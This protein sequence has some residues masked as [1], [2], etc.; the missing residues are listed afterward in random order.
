MKRVFRAGLLATAAILLSSG[1]GD[2]D[3]M[4]LTPAVSFV[5]VEP[6]IL[7]TNTAESGGK[8]RQVARFT[9]HND[10]AT[11]LGPGQHRVELEIGSDRYTLTPQVTLEPLADTTFD[12][13]VD[14][15]PPGAAATLSVAMFFENALQFRTSQPWQHQRQWKLY[16]APFSHVD[17]GYT[18]SQQAVLTKQLH[19]INAA[20]E[21][22][23]QTS[24]DPAYD[25]DSRFS[26][27]IEG[28]WAAFEYLRTSD[29]QAVERFLG[30]VRAGRIEVA[31]LLNNHTNKFMG[32]EALWRSLYFSAER[33]QREHGVPVASALLHD[34]GDASSVV[35]PLYRCGIRYIQY[36]ANTMHYAIPPL[37]YFQEPSDPESRL[38]MWFPPNVGEYGENSTL[39]LRP[40]IP[41]SPLEPHDPNAP[42][43]ADYEQ[44]VLDH[45][46]WLQSRGLPPPGVLERFD[47]KGFHADY[48]YDA[49]LVTY[50]PAHDGDNGVQDIT[51][52]D[53][54]RDWNKKYVYPRL[55]VA[56]VRD[57]FEYV[58][59]NFPERI[60]SLTGDFPGFWGE[61]IFF[62]VLQADPEKEARNR[63]FTNQ[64]ATAEK[65]GVVA[66]QLAPSFSMST[67]DVDDAFEKIIL[68]NDHNPGPVPLSGYPFTQDDVQAWK[69]TRKQWSDETAAFAEGIENS[70]VSAVA[71]RVSVDGPSIVVFN[72]SSWERQE[73]VEAEIDPA[74]PRFAIVTDTGEPV[75]Y[76]VI[77]GAGTPTRIAFEAS[78]LPAVGYRTF[79]IVT[80]D[81]VPGFPTSL[82]VQQE[83]GVV[84][85]ENRFYRATI[86]SQA[87]GG[88]ISLWDKELGRE[89]VRGDARYRLDQFVQFTRAQTVGELGGTG[90]NLADAPGFT[91]VVANVA[92]NGPVRAIVRLTG[93][94]NSAIRIPD[95]IKL[96]I[97]F[98]GPFAVQKPAKLPPI[99]QSNQVNL[100]QDIVFYDQI[101]RVDFVQQFSDTPIQLTENAFAY[102]VDVPGFTLKAEFPYNPVRIGP[103]DPFALYG[104]PPSQQGDLLMTATYQGASNLFSLPTKWMDGQPPDNMFRHWLDVSNSDFGVTFSARESGAIVPGDFTELTPGQFGQQPFAPLPAPGWYH[105]G[106]GPTWLG[107]LLYGLEAG[108]SY[109][110]HASLTSHRGR[111]DAIENFAGTRT[112][113]QFGWGF[114]TPLDVR[115]Q[116]VPQE[117]S[118]PPMASFVQIDQPN[119]VLVTMKRAEDG[120]AIV[121]RLYETNGLATR[122]QITL[123]FL[124]CISATLA[125]GVERSVS[126]LPSRGSAFTLDLSPGMV[127]T[128]RVQSCAEASR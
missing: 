36:S 51:P 6:T 5:S 45:L 37:F 55:K 89:L 90:G 62:S 25:T 102:P 107:Q 108:G 23:E 110:F 67:Q 10:T 43:P 120:R 76:Q 124:A 63:A 27:T 105:L 75:P 13:F 121:L 64:I 109:T 98:L 31:G 68:N 83:G 41:S 38:L 9:V 2:D 28:S 116:P 29:P 78:H 80:I 8:T 4:T 113:A 59:Q 112:A 66:A 35:Q 40:P 50:Y 53:V 125:D 77:S 96:V 47:M 85:L 7:F 128:V 86:D 123:P 93:T 60:P 17:V 100:V 73:V 111:A 11:P 101:K 57:F 104:I 106:V 48:P 92:E 71:E 117:G 49:Y 33:M 44:R 95:G 94:Y 79:H 81:D 12:V 65:F 56:R 91:A 24:A 84:I 119:V 20:M 18:N 21:L 97:G 16:L 74:G 58:E 54:A 70:S 15:L 14:P 118:L 1:C 26:Y 99:P 34:V 42:L 114:T 126:P 69:D 72:P 39:G 30:H 52:S 32:D 46:T 87:S 122:A 127:A 115:V 103:N 61:Q 82:Q 22:I 88:I 3:K 19:N